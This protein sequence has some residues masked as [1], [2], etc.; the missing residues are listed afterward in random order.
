MSNYPDFVAINKIT[1]DEDSEYRYYLSIPFCT[2]NNLDTL[3]VLMKN[4]SNANAKLSDYTANKVCNFA[5]SQKY[6]RVVIVNLFAYRAKDADVL[7]SM[8]DQRGSDYI[9]GIKNDSYIRKAITEASRIIVAWGKPPK[10]FSGVY[11]TRITQVHKILDG[12]ELYYVETLWDNKYP[13]HGLRWSIDKSMKK[14]F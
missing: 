14:L 4:P 5:Y 11:D 1:V 2:I 10:N 3:V 9:I 7:K 12:N 13:L 8:C 6:G